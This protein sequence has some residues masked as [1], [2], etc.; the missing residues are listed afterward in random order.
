[1]TKLTESEMLKH[2]EKCEKDACG[3]YGCKRSDIIVTAM[4]NDKIM[5][6]L[7]DAALRERQKNGE[8]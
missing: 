1:M 2:V 8:V 5:I 3:V 7:K 6:R 4:P